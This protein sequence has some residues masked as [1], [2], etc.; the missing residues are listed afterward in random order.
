MARGVRCRPEQIVITT[1]AQ[2][3][4][5]LL[6]RVLLD[7]GDAAWVEEPGYYGAQAAFVAAGA[8]LVPLHVERPG[9]GARAA[10]RTSRRGSSM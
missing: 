5:D 3:A 4:L 2:A 6:A 9:L 7:A 10:R 8:Q 1:G